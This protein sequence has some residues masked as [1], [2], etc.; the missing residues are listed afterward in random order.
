MRVRW[1][2]FREKIIEGAV[3][4][5]GFASIVFVALI[6]ALLLRYA[7]PGIREVGLGALLTG[8]EWRPTATEPQFGLLPLFLGSLLV[9][10]TALALAVPVGVGCAVFLAEMAPAR[11][12]E[13][14][15][16]VIELLAA[17][18]SVVFGF[19][20]LAV[21]GKGIQ[22]ICS[23]LGQAEWLP[24]GLASALTMPTPLAAITGG[25]VLAGMALP[26]IVSIS[27]DALRAVP[28]RFR[29]ASLALGGTRWQTIRGMTLPAA[30]SGVLA[31]VM[32]G[33]GRTIGETMT[34]LMVT[35]NAAV[36]PGFPDGLFRS[37]RTLTATIAAEMGETA[38]DS[39]H[40]RMLFALGLA[41]FLITFAVNTAA[42]IATNRVT[43]GSRS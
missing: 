36:M 29:D 19:L 5:A 35:G 24:A 23:W 28:R 32:L 40:F 41:L 14:V 13:A 18:P 22:A 2:R 8:K 31:A 33:V 43:H 16:P 38:H 26:T 21:A 7:V 15:K 30:R 6:L 11:V 39:A 9:T 27:E 17:V 3:H 42:D 10:A 12:R 25:V 37:V 1:S 20:G 34:V 4:A